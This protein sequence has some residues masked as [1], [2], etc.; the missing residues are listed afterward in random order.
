[1]KG[2]AAGLSKNKQISIG[3]N[4]MYSQTRKQTR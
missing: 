3:H 1:M 4:I 2:Q